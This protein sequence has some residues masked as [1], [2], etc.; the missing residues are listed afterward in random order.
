M[1]YGYIFIRTYFL[2]SQRKPFKELG[3]SATGG[4]V[5]QP[6][7]A[8]LLYGCVPNKAPEVRQMSWVQ[9]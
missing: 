8:L 5:A 3:L 6:G 2:D 4:P 9:K 1:N 7:G